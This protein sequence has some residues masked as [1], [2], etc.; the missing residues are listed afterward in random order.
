MQVDF[1]E[2]NLQT[3][4]KKLAELLKIPHFTLEQTAHLNFGLDE[5]KNKR[6]Q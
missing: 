5:L 4:N 6:V 2:I 3:I 1:N